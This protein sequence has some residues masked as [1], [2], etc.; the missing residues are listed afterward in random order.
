M[1]IKFFGAF[2]HH[3]QKFVSP[4]KKKKTLTYLDLSV[5]AFCKAPYSV[6]ILMPF[7]SIYVSVTTN[8]NY[9]KAFLKNFLFA[10]VP[11]LRNLWSRYLSIFVFFKLPDSSGE[12]FLSSSVIA[13]V[14]RQQYQIPLV[15]VVNKGYYLN[16]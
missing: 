13:S 5:Y 9:E 15:P 2:D 14:A 4:A 12:H 3:Y 7:L 6:I 1:S 16:L 8:Y 10:L 11:R